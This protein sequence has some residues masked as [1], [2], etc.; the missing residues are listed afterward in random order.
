MKD[1]APSTPLHQP[2]RWLLWLASSMALTSLCFV[3]MPQPEA[4]AVDEALSRYSVAADQQYVRGNDLMLQ[5]NYTDAA[6]AYRRAVSL[7]SRQSAY[8]RGLGNALLALESPSDA[9]VAYRQ[10]LRLNPHDALSYKS[11]GDIF[12]QQDRRPEAIEAY[13]NAITAGPNLTVAY[14]RLG[15]LLR[16]EGKLD[17]AMYNYQ[18]AIS[19]NF[20]VPEAHYELAITLD[21]MGR[22][23]EAKKALERA[24]ALYTR[25][26]NQ[27][28]VQRIAAL[29]QREE[30][31]RP[32]R[33]REVARNEAEPVRFNR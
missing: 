31:T 17:E 15:N 11:L 24:L 25:Q 14:V 19:T 1:S 33:R 27:A 28:G 18:Q 9:A 26:N 8:Y 13:R 32:R 6:A 10:A 16:Q 12:V 4:K 22:K 30:A 3:S 29:Q 7:N 5:G 20:S 2:R 23:E 21:A